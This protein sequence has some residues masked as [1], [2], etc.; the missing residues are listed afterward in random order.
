MKQILFFRNNMKL[1]YSTLLLASLCYPLTAYSAD[2]FF[3]DEIIAHTS[4]S[5]ESFI[6]NSGL[7]SMCN[8]TEY[9]NCLGLEQDKCRVDLNDC[10][11]LL[12]EVINTA[13]SEPIMA[14]FNQC[15]LSKNDFTDE[16]YDKC[17]E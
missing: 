11:S 2:S 7:K 10:L 15:L 8:D 12:P 14:K 4:F 17:E 9:L 5:K 3:Q 6:V 1:Q 13:E 16:K